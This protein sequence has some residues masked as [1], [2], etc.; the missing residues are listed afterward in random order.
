[1]R[2]MLAVRTPVVI[3]VVS[4]LGAATAGRNHPYTASRGAP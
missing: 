2:R 3:V 1:M 4:V